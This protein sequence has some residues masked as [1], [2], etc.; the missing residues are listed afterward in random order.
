MEFYKVVLIIVPLW[1]I[2]F[3]LKEILVELKKNRNGSDY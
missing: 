1:G 3:T 2:A